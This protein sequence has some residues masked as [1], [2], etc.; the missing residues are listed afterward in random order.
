[1]EP[2]FT[3][4]AIEDA[5][6]LAFAP[7]GRGLLLDRGGR[8]LRVEGERVQELPGIAYCARFL[9]EQPILTTKQGQTLFGILPSGTPVVAYAAEAVASQGILFSILGDPPVHCREALLPGVT[10][11]AIESGALWLLGAD[12]GVRLRQGR[13]GFTVTRTVALP[14]PAGAASIG[15]DGALYVGCGASLVR[16]SGEE[17][18]PPHPLS[19]VLRDLA[20]RGASLYGLAADRILD[21]THLVPAPDG[22]G[23]RF[24]IPSCSA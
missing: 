16:V 24:A 9:S 10:A 1:M 2:P 6:S 14:A 13:G 20:R 7:S 18:D 5:T 11:I 3:G 19:S 22:E 21:L 15:P 8:R 12:R 4:A 23:P 17:P